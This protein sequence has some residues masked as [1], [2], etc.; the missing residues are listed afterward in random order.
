M[1]GIFARWTI[2]LFPTVMEVSEML[3]ILSSS[4]Y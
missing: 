4:K 2:I 1:H 3:D